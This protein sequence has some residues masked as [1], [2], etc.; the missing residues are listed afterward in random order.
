MISK[1]T[2][3]KIMD[4]LDT[5][6]QQEFTEAFAKAFEPV[7]NFKKR[8]SKEEFDEKQDWFLKEINR[9]SGLPEYTKF[10]ADRPIIELSNGTYREMQY[11]A[12]KYVHFIEDEAQPGSDITYNKMWLYDVIKKYYTVQ[13]FYK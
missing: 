6:K 5:E 9:L 11:L 7:K 3:Y 10:D 13:S 1:N 4:Q 8:L 12:N 2:I